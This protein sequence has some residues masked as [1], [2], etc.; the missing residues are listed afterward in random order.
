MRQVCNASLLYPYQYHYQVLQDYTNEVVSLIRLLCFCVNLRQEPF[1]GFVSIKYTVVM[2][3]LR[4]F[5][6]A[7]LARLFASLLRDSEVIFLGQIAV[8]PTCETSKLC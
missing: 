3:Y 8:R 7:P 4:I 2:G 6:G 5:V 1:F